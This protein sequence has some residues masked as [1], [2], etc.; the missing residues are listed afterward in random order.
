MFFP[1]KGV[2]LFHA[3]I[4][5]L[6]NHGQGLGGFELLCLLQGFLCHVGSSLTVPAWHVCYKQKCFQRQI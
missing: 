5:K 3:R 4:V 2:H 1:V 6:T